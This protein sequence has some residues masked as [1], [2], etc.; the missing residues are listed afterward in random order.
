MCLEKELSKSQ[1]ESIIV[2]KKLDNTDSR[3]S[4][5]INYSISSFE[6]EELKHLVVSNKK[7]TVKPLLKY[8]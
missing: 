2:A 1:R 4:A 7:P 5:V 3:I 8:D 6:Y